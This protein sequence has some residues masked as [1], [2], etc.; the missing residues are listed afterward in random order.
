MTRS[1][2][3]ESQGPDIQNIRLVPA[4]A[5]LP[6]TGRVERRDLTTR[7]ALLRRICCEFME[8]PGVSL[9]PAQANRLLG[10][11]PEVAHRILSRLTEERV[12]RLRQDGQY[13]LRIEEP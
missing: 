10:L 5:H 9:T 8:M 4:A 3:P 1:I 7:E 13:T 2:A 11:A 12:L 6:E